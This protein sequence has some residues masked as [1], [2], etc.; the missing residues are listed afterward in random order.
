MVAHGQAIGTTRPVTWRQGDVMDLPFPDASFDVVVCQ[1]SVMF[2]PDRTSA[3]REIRR[4]LRPGG[5]FLFNVWN[6]IGQNEFA[7]VV[8]EA[9]GTLYPEDPPLFLARTPHGHGAPR[10]IEGDLRA[11]GFESVSLTQRDDVSVASGPQVPAVAYCQGTPLRNEIL[12][13]D[14]DGLEEAT[15]VAS[16]AIR[17][18]FGEGRIEGRISGVVVV[19]GKGPG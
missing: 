3:Y 1:F 14:P 9:L 8:T 18:R 15:A 16:E 6:S 19:S 13:R 11:S 17:S 7:Q 10:E 5:V 2:F 4:L 12:A